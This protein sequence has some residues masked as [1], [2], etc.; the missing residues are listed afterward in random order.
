MNATRGR[1]QGKAVSRWTDDELAAAVEAYRQMEARLADGLIP[2][3]ARI[4]RDL[5]TR[6]G[7][8]PKAWEYRMQNISHVLDQTGKPWLPGLLPASNVG[9]RVEPKLAKLL[10]L[11]CETL[12]S[13]SGPTRGLLEQEARAAEASGS[14]SPADEVDERQRV[15]AAIVRRRG[16]PAFRKALLD[17][18][19]SC[20]A[21][22]GC[23]VVDALEAA[24]IQP[25]SGLKS[26]DVRNGLL[27]RADVHTL[28]DLYLI[29]INPGS[30]R[31]AVAPALQ[32]STYVELDGRQLSTPMPSELSA[33]QESLTWHRSQCQW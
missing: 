14:F 15:L 29:T 31:I 22:T 7:R 8:T 24:H 10:G 2:E 4:Y 18:Y 32:H 28:F 23:D 25:Y 27:L 9:A 5:A 17:A 16:Q 33:Y 12:T 11:S 13:I 26:N 1:G 20:C 21:M 6:H 19:G 3:K 30:L